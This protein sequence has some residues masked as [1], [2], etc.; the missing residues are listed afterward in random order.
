MTYS[1]QGYA[2]SVKYKADKIKRI[3]LDVQTSFYDEIKAAADQA[4]ETVNG[5]IKQAIRTRLAADQVQ[6]GALGA[7]EDNGSG[8]VGPVSKF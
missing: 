1:K 7:M 5:F 8:R 2:A 3:P 4:G 6:A